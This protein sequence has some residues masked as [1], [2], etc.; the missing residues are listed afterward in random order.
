[1][2]IGDEVLVQIGDQL[3]PEKVINV[4]NFAMQGRYNSTSENSIDSDK[5]IME[6]YRI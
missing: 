1:M 6:S 5:L 4:S 2:S 3:F